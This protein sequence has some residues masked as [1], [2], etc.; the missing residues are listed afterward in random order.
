[1]RRK[2]HTNI[3][4][5]QKV[6]Y[7]DVYSGI[8]LVYYGNQSQLEYD[9]I[10]APGA[11]PTRITMA[12]EGAE[13]IEVDEEGD[14]VLTVLPS[15]DFTGKDT[16]T[17]RLQKP[18]VYQIGDAGERHFLDGTYVLLDSETSSLRPASAVLHP[19]GTAHPS[20]SLPPHVALQVASYDTSKPLIIDPVLSWATYLGRQWR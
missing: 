18:V 15:T 5:Y 6:G 14:L 10:V 1:M 11:D 17:L 3:P 13:Q 4:T 16:P 2:W 19:H 20:T 7:K 8:D 12:F 9:L